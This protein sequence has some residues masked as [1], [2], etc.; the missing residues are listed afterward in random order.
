MS[1]YNYWNLAGITEKWSL[2]FRHEHTFLFSAASKPAVG[3]T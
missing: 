1:Y 2:V 3:R